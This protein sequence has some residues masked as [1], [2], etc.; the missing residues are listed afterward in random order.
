[1]IRRFGGFTIVE[2]LVVAAIVALV[3]SLTYPLYSSATRGAKLGVSASNMRQLYVAVALYRSAHDGDGRY[4]DLATMGLPDARWALLDRGGLPESLMQS[5]CGSHPSE[6]PS[7]L[8]VLYHPGDG[9]DP[10]PMWLLA[11]KENLILYS[12]IQCTP[13][14]NALLNPYVSKTG[15][16]VLL[17]GTIVRRAKPGD[18]YRPDWW[19]EPTY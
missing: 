17:G 5:P 8:Q 2:V 14:E 12:D 16:G 9:E 1:M 18:P 4:G 10:F 7:V 6:Q 19:A 13:P 3:A 11:Y 15:V